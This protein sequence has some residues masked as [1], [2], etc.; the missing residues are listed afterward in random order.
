MVQCCLF[1]PFHCLRPQGGITQGLF[2]GGLSPLD[3]NTPDTPSGEI[4][5]CQKLHSG[6]RTSAALAFLFAMRRGKVQR[7]TARQK[8]SGRVGEVAR[9]GG[10]GARCYC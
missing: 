4:P 8:R 3:Q 9:V 7:G 1:G 2:R 5:V 10:R 6:A